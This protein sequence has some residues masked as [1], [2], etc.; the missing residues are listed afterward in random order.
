[1]EPGNSRAIRLARGQKCTGSAERYN[2][3]IPPSE[4]S[5][6]EN[7]RE[8]WHHVRGTTGFGGCE[9]AGDGEDDVE[10]GA[11]A[12]VDGDRGVGVGV[13]GVAAND[14]GFDNSAS[15]SLDSTRS[16]S[17]SRRPC[18]CVPTLCSYCAWGC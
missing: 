14:D 1:M 8:N 2:L 11:C 6:R 4:E 13:A 5:I 3:S 18:S 17:F 9:D 16:S 15:L 10:G 7:A 12:A